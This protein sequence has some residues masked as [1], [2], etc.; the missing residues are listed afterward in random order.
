MTISSSMEE[1]SPRLFVCV[2]LLMLPLWG[3]RTGI[4]AITP[5]QWLILPLRQLRGMFRQF[6]ALDT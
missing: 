2:T 5:K 3:H 4:E 6:T 1:I